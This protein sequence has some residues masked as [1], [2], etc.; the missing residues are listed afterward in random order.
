MP[1]GFCLQGQLCGLHLLVFVCKY[2]YMV[3]AC[4]VFVYRDSYV[5]YVC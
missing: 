1:A 4:L 3:Y 5:I 2:S